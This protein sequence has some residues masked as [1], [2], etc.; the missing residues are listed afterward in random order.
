LNGNP[1]EVIV[2]IHKA[3]KKELTTV[4]NPKQELGRVPKPWRN[5]DG[6]KIEE[7]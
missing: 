4:N 6:S 5:A 3:S 1:I 7:K 2:S